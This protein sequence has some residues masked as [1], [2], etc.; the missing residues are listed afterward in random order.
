MNIDL[1]PLCIIPMCQIAVWEANNNKKQ[2]FPLS[3][4]VLQSTMCVCHFFDDKQ[5]EPNLSADF[6]FEL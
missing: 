2:N 1:P 6:V 3:H 4:R 5:F